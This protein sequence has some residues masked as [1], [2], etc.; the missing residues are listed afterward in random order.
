MNCYR[1]NKS[2]VIIIVAT[3]ALG[4]SGCSKK[5]D[6]HP[7]SQPPVAGNWENEGQ[8]AG[9]S[10]EQPDLASGGD[11][12]RSHDRKAITRIQ[13]DK[14]YVGTRK[15]NNETQEIEVIFSQNGNYVTMKT[16][17]LLEHLN[18]HAAVKSQVSREVSFPYFYF[19]NTAGKVLHWM[20]TLPFFLVNEKRVN[21]GNMR[22]DLDVYMDG[23]E[24]EG[25]IQ[26]F[27]KPDDY[28]TDEEIKIKR[29]TFAKHAKLGTGVDLSRFE[30]KDYSSLK[31]ASQLPFS[32]PFFGVINGELDP[33]NYQ[34][35]SI[36]PGGAFYVKEDPSG[37]GVTVVGQPFSYGGKVVFYEKEGSIIMSVQHYDGKNLPMDKFSIFVIPVQKGTGEILFG[38]GRYWVVEDNQIKSVGSCVAQFSIGTDQTGWK[39]LHGNLTIYERSQKWLLTFKNFLWRSYTPRVD[40][41]RYIEVVFKRYLGEKAQSV[42]EGEGEGK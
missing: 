2:L 12:L 35:I 42:K 25:H 36:G 22:F 1:M 28:Q 4:L 31:D 33:G 21:A 32:L 23:E 20:D 9:S 26:M 10:G 19:E 18:D 16:Y 8:D 6:Q 15:I 17:F 13:F 29:G 38:E 24:I 7:G 30:P 5:K 14:P 37:F 41:N 27:S 39:H 11:Q 34:T 40:E 3:L